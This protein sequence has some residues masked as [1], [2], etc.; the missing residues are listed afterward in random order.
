MKPVEDLI[1]NQKV[2]KAKTNN[3]YWQKDSKGSN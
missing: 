2:K 3:K 1:K